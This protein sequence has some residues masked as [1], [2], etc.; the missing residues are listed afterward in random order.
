MVA[1]QLLKYCHYLED[2]QGYRMELRYLRDTDGRETDFVVLK[3]GKA[4]FAVEVKLS[5]EAETKAMRYFK[6]RTDISNY[7]LVHNGNADKVQQGIRILP[8]RVFCQEL[9]MP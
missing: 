1:C 5:D 6:E 2:D 4:L 7:Y 9:E 8:L 3:D